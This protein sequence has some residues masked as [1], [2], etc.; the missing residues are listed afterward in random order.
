[1]S[2]HKNSY[3][4]VTDNTYQSIPSYPS[5]NNDRQSRKN[6]PQRPASFN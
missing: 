4:N 6:P 3:E 2:F 5:Y 1:M